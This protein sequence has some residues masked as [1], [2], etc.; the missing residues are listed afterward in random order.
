M[1]TRLNIKKLDGNVVQKH[2]GSKQVGLKQ[3][4][5]KQVGF[6]QLGV[7]QVR[8]KQLGL[9]V[10]ARV[11]GVH[12][13]KTRL[14]DKQLE[15]KTNTDCLVNKQV[16]H[17]ANVGALIMKTRVP[18]Q[19]GAEGNAVERYRCDSNM[20]ALGGAGVI[21][22]YAHESL[23]FRDVVAC[24]VISKWISVMKEHMDTRSSMCILINRSRRSN[25]DNNIYYWKYAPVGFKQLGVKQVRFKQLGLG[26]EARVHGV[27]DEKTRLEDKQLEEK[28]N[29]DC[30]VNKQVHHGAN[31][32]ALIMKT[33]VPGQEGAEG[34]A[35]ERYR[36]DSNMAALGGAG[37]IEEYAHESLT[38]RDVVAYY[39]GFTCESKAEIWV[40][41]GLL[42]EAKEI[43]LSMEI[44]RTQSVSLEAGLSGNHDEEKKSKGLLVYV[45]YWKMKGGYIAK[46]TLCRVS[47]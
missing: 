21:E 35:V 42:E 4:G 43:I 29:T 6:K 30:L 47:I 32:G 1:N 17:G 10:E 16:H 14:E 3:L 37:V 44:L 19:E 33:R 15:E 38:F 46:G 24:E 8:F 39:M 23:T 34:N 20:A 7:K 18:G 12:D 41:K 45:T 2:G 36:C 26:V 11:H 27:H 40:T 13:E 31:V 9:G 5:S 25:D 22:E 28:T